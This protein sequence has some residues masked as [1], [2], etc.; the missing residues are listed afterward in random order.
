MFEHISIITSNFRVFVWA[1]DR[2]NIQDCRLKMFCIDAILLEL[3]C[4][5][6]FPHPIPSLDY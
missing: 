6:C 5:E 1:L 3:S 2:V 4:A